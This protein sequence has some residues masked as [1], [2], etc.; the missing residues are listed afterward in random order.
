[1]DEKLAIDKVWP[2]WELVDELGEGSC[3][4]VYKAV[5]RE[6]GLE[7]YSA[8]KIISV[9]KNDAVFIAVSR[10]GYSR[11]DTKAYFRGIVDELIKEIKAMESLKGTQNVVSIE[12]FKVVEK[13]DGK[14][15]NIYIRMELLVSFEDYI[16]DKKLTRDE[17][18]KLGTDICFALELCARKNII[19]RDIK[20]ENIFI[21]DFGFFKLGD[22]GIARELG[23]TYGAS[24]KTGTPNYMAPEVYHCQKYNATAD[25][26][27]LGLV[28]YKLLNN[29]RLPFL[30][31]DKQ[32]ISYGER[33]VA[34]EKRMCG[35]PLP[36]PANAYEKLAEVILKACAYDPR[37]RYQ[38]AAEFKQALEAV[39][40]QYKKVTI[41]DE[42]ETPENADKVED[43][44][45]M[46][47]SLN[48]ETDTIECCMVEAFMTDETETDQDNK[49]KKLL[50]PDV[51]EYDDIYSTEIV[52]E[53]E[54]Y[55]DEITEKE[56]EKDKKKNLNKKTIGIIVVV[57]TFFAVGTMIASKTLIPWIMDA[58]EFGVNSANHVI[59]ED[60]DSRAKDFEPDVYTDAEMF[61]YWDN[62]TGEINI[63]LYT[64]SDV[65][66]KIPSEIEEHPVTSIGANAFAGTVIESIVIPEG[67]VTIGESAFKNCTSLKRAAIPEGV[68]AI[69]DYTFYGCSKLAEVELPVSLESIGNDAFGLVSC[70][71]SLFIPRDV[72]TI[73]D[74]AFSGSTL[75]NINVDN[76]NN[77]FEVKDGVLFTKGLKKLV[78]YPG[79]K[80]DSN[81]VFPKETTEI[82]E[83][84]FNGTTKLTSVVLPEKMTSI[85]EHAFYNCGSLHKI[86]L[87]D[88]LKI[89]SEAAFWSCYNLTDINLPENVTTIGGYA[90]HASG[91]KTVYIPQRVTKIGAQSFTNCES[92]GSIDVDSDNK[93][94]TSRDG[95]LY[96]KDNKTLVQYPAGKEDNSLKIPDG[97]TM[98]KPA[99]F[100]GCADLQIVD[101]PEG[102]K[103]IDDA[104]FE[105]CHSLNIITL[106]DSISIINC[107]A[108]D[109]CDKLITVNLND[110][111]KE[112]EG[113]AFYEC[114]SLTEISIPESVT[115]IGK[116]AFDGCGTD[117]G[118]FVIK[119]TSGSYAETYAKENN[120]DFQAV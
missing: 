64:G 86:T 56:E 14:G 106:A 67:I 21:S 101:L 94:Y 47:F 26:Y 42:L 24:T 28:L 117:S 8:I 120:I 11:D 54:T 9:P 91:L 113:S 29:N 5:K 114:S 105:N 116:G 4:T 10:E 103:I 39:A 36:A 95:I 45:T 52:D 75:S 63:V 119:G 99:A 71:T 90:F 68:T 88:N 18:V 57:L 97:T 92:L 62:G 31:P 17:I 69:E 27:S 102:M 12:D 59:K 22:F 104:A 41:V 79:G 85:S 53:T 23:K 107:G 73:G 30:D 111:L 48:D 108:F 44:N 83:M 50:V 1:M 43:R 87:P 93:Y 82:S 89:I 110:N 55:D 58:V 16:S 84:A 78:Q 61:K 81:F 6:H 15:W 40:H 7:T 37:E 112:I 80:S 13:E 76:E 51:T 109:Y 19:H 72:E 2:G 66:V 46:E 100:I 70:L 34:F 33:N 96:T 77:F 115:T 25:I 98:I 74:G 3:G 32:L 60:N 20:P 49:T 65:N 118:K 38:S 35:V